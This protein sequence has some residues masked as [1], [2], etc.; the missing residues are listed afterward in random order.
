MKMLTLFWVQL[1]TQNL[2]EEVIV[3]IIATGCVN[4]DQQL[5]T[6]LR[7]QNTIQNITLRKKRLKKNHM[8]KKQE[9]VLK[10]AALHQ[11]TED[12]VQSKSD[13]N[14][15]ELPKVTTEADF[16]DLDVPTYLRKQAQQQDNE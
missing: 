15:V 12:V 14:I 13:Q 10:P 8:K 9:V 16:N 1:L 7:V 3:T 4:N 2:E 11:P 5:H 6:P